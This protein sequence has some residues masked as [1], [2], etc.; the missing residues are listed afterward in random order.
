[1]RRE[2]RR[3][4]NGVEMGEEELDGLVDS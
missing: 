1:M 4:A 2:G 3:E